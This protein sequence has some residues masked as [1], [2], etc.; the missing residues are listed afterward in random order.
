MFGNRPRL[1]PVTKLFL[2]LLFLGF[3]GCKQT[4]APQRITGQQSFILGVV[5]DL[6]GPMGLYGGW[7]KKGVELA[8]KDLAAAGV[9]VRVIA[10]DSQS[11]PKNAVSA[12]Q[13]L[14]DIN[15][16]RF[17]IC[18]T[19]S[20][21]TMAIAPIIN[22]RRAILMVTLAS[23]PSITGAGDYIFRNRISG[24]FEAKEAARVAKNRGL[25]KVATIAINN[26]SGVPYIE[27]FATEFISLGGEVVSK[28]LLAPGQTDFRT[29]I[30]RLRASRPQ[31]VFAALDVDQVSRV[32]RQST[33]MG[34]RST[35]IGIS[36]IKTPKLLELA[37]SSAEG[38]FVVSEG[39]DETSPLYKTLSAK[40]RQAFNED[41]T[42][43]AVNGYDAAMLLAML[44]QKC[45]AN[46]DAVKQAL[47]ALEGY[48]GV[49]GKLR[50]DINGDAI[51]TVR[52]YEVKNKAFVDVQ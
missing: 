48:E 3:I 51:R 23:S 42:L 29:S 25:I 8:H 40:Y 11:E 24:L 4:N 50:F 7:V 31:A 34:F 27:A 45:K 15:E 43:Y 36:S 1:L 22:K 17:I 52:V 33:E 38:I 19:G 30:I 26:E 10:E 44:I 5:A 46:V 13:K 18:G 6:T 20:S 41:L 21:G 32:L 49:G 28:D 39:V 16:A 2:S 14:L 35:W 37:G 47:Y 9:Q 12:L